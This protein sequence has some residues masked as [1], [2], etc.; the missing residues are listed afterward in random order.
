MRGIGIQL[1]NDLELAVQPVRDASGR[2]VA[3]MQLGESLYQNQALILVMHPGSLKLSP[4][5]GVGIS[6]ALLDNDFLAWRQKVRRQMELDGQK[7]RSVQFSNTEN[8]ELDA[9]Y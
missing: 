8:L 2:I 3:G 1:N 9:S 6:D 7:V 5:V 4:L